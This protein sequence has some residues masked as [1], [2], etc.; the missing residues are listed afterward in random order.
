MTQP[1]FD[2]VVRDIS[3]ATQE[4]ISAYL[5]V[6]L[7]AEK[8]MRGMQPISSDI[9]GIIGFGG[10]RV[11]YLLFSAGAP[12][13]KKVAQAMLSVDDADEDAMRDAIGE[14]TNNIAGIFKRLHQQYGEVALGLPL[15]VSGAVRAPT[16]QHHTGDSVNMDFKGVTIPFTTA[17]GGLHFRVMVLA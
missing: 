4:V 10:A 2:E 11:G 8:V 5:G 7:V 1:S 16:D 14:L 3:G 17:D 13:A 12:T 6:Q 15:V 9:V